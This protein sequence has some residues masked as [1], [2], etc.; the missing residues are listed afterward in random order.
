MY[1]IS[2]LSDESNKGVFFYVKQVT[3]FGKHLKMATGCQG[4]QTCD[5]EG[6][7]IQPPNPNLKGGEWAGD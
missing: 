6:W 1:F 2:V 7:N 4:K 5:S 3:F